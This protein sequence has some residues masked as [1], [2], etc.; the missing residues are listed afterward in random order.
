MWL[1]QN[2]CTSKLSTL[3]RDSGYESIVRAVKDS[4]DYLVENQIG[5]RGDAGSSA[6]TFED[7]PAAGDQIALVTD[8]DQEPAAE[9]MVSDTTAA[10]S[11]IFGRPK[12]NTQAHSRDLKQRIRLVIADTVK[13][14]SDAFHA[15]CQLRLPNAGTIQRIIAA[16]KSKHAL[17]DN[18]VI[19]ADTIRSLH[20]RRSL[21]LELE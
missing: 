14:Y 20:K 1:Q 11:V 10:P 9:T 17:A 15:H 2:S 8:N 13:Q 7:S 21:N 3:S 12:G 5:L 4:P 19:N 16:A 18:V 6:F